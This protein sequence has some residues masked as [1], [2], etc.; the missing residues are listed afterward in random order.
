MIAF[1]EN[2]ADYFLIGDAFFRGF[3]SVHD[4]DND[5]IGFAPHSES[6]KSAAV[7]TSS[8]PQN[9]IKLGFF[10]KYKQEILIVVGSVLVVAG[11][12]ILT[13]IVWPKVWKWFKGKG[14]AKDVEILYLLV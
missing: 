3:Y 5:R 11:L 8:P 4:D 14:R 2:D 13:T 7:F 1:T 10:V 6:N 12:A 9:S